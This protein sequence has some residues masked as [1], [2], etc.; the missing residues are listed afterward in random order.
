MLPLQV[1][2]GA[3]EAALQTA[4]RQAA[5]AAEGGS[6]G[7]TSAAAAAAA[8][9]APRQLLERALK[10]LPKRKHVKALTRWGVDGLAGPWVVRGGG[11][12]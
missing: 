4:Q 3:F 8:A 9:N 12:G 7:D 10:S 6:S 5:A 11:G 1:W 2:L